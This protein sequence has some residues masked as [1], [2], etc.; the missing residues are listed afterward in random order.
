MPLT[1]IEEIYAE[2]R[3]S[4]IKDV[5]P[6]IN[7]F[8]RNAI[9]INNTKQFKD[10]EELELYIQLIGD[11]TNAVYQKGHYNTAIDLVDK[12][13]VFVDNEIQRLNATEIKNDWYYS[14]AL[15]KGISLYNLKDYKTSTPI[16]KKLVVISPQNDNFKNWLHLSQ[17]WQRQWLLRIISIILIIMFVI[18]TFFKKYIPF[19]LGIS[20]DIIALVG[21]IAINIY[22]HYIRRS[23]RKKKKQS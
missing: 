10:K 6:R 2:F 19:A 7:F 16:F 22:E 9:I 13:Q 11:Y 17:V 21:I 20:F 3:A 8:E 18:R 14:L 1:T 23:F 15:I 5:D 12:Y 4:Y